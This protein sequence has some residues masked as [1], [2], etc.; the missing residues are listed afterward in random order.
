MP[1]VKQSKDPH[2]NVVGFTLHDYLELVDWAG[3]AVREGK[4]G[5]IKASV[6]SILQRLSL[7]P[8]RFLEHIQGE[9]ETER[10]K[11]LGAV[12]RIRQVAGDLGRRFL[13]GT[14]EGRKLYLSASVV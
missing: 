5:V 8:S 10:P 2:R 11:V 1:L 3:R 6:P 14:G 13:R 12:Q 4:R 9:A 7:E